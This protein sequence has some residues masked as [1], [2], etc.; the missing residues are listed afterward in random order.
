MKEKLSASDLESLNKAVTEAVDWLEKH[1]NDEKADYDAKTKEV[2]QV[3]NPI[4]K[5]AYQSGA[6]PAG[7]VHVQRGRADSRRALTRLRCQKY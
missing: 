4:L 3:A 7:R 2:E 6:A 1:P 5:T